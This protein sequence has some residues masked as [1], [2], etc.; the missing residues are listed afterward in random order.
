M[1]ISLTKG[2][3]ISLAKQDGGALTNVTLGLGWDSVK[4]GGFFGFG[5]EIDLD[6]SAILYNGQGQALDV[7]YFG[8]LNSND[9]S[10][11]HTG[12]NLTGAGDGDDE[13]IR[14]DLSR[15]SPEIQN[16]VFTINSYSGQT[17]DKVS[18][19]FARVL[20]SSTGR[21]DEIV[22]YNL[23]ES[24]Q[25]TANIIAKLSRNGSGWAFTAIGE[26]TNGKTAQKLVDPARAYL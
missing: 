16:I 15:V 23:A 5:G 22:R 20:D 1:S 25:N 6:A 9:R 24:K 17:F 8:K 21:N 2:S 11:Q 18:N 12:D 26:F 13:Q 19:V 10:V 4:K 7:V 3:S 14:V